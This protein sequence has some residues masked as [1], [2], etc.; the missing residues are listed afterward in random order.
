MAFAPAA[1]QELVIDGVRYR[2]EEHPGAPGLP[3]GQQGRRGTVYLL[4][5]GAE[6]RALKVFAP[7]FRD[8]AQAVRSEQVSRA[9]ALPGLRVAERTVL[10]PLRHAA[11]LR[12]HPDLAY[13]VLMPWV[14]GPTWA[15]L[16]SARQPLTPEQSL[17]TAFALARVVTGLQEAGA[18]HGDL[19]GGNLVLPVFAG[20]HGD[21][22]AT[23][24]VDVEEICLPGLTPPP[25]LP[26]GSPGY[27]HPEV[28]DGY[29]G[30]RADRFASSLLLAEIL[31][32]SDPA[33]CGAAWGEAYFHPDEVQ[34]PG[35]RYR[36]LWQSLRSRWGEPAAALL[37]AAWRAPTLNDC[38]DMA[39]WL[40]ALPQQVP[41]PPVSQARREAEVVVIRGDS[42]T[43][44]VGPLVQGA[45]EA[46]T[47][48]QYA[49][50]VELL[51]EVL[52]REPDHAEQGVATAAWL[53]AVK[54]RSQAGGRG[55]APPPVANTLAIACAWVIAVL[56]VG[57][58]VTDWPVLGFFAEIS[59][60]LALMAEL[61]LAAAIWLLVRARRLRRAG[62][63]G[64]PWLAAVFPK[65]RGDGVLPVQRLHAEVLYRLGRLYEQAGHLR[66]AAAL[67][68]ET[69]QRWP[70]HPRAT[71]RLTRLT[72][73]AR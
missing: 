50:A 47:A 55:P 22:S 59:L 64:P 24:L 45:R 26:A 70:G 18:A 1:G 27:A 39:A 20:H 28:R 12:Q 3:Y 34:R 73:G 29:W 63:A 40:C 33:V 17:Q 49:R 10:T 46:V 67:Y 8:P 16:L 53:E 56:L 37:E 68:V 62:L 41:R 9:A 7:A 5:S 66:L 35:G 58:V 60:G 25:F 38:P 61:G 57:G 51:T 15:E 32:W 31:G 23:E 44:G 52:R 65:D 4:A 30:P 14:E 43:A 42:G 72:N 19:S 54:V 36:T 2:V 11:L 13:A 69:A 71:Q 21:G 6:R 48:G